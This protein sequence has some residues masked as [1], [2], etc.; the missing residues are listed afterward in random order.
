MT[1]FIGALGIAFIVGMALGYALGD[2]D[3]Y[4]RK[5]TEVEADRDQKFIPRAAIIL[6]EHA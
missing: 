1:T 3:G 2:R 4:R 5:Q 6:G